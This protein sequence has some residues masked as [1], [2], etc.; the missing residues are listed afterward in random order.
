MRASILPLLL[1][2]ACG[3][4]PTTTVRSR[5]EDVAKAAFEALK[6]GE[7]GPLEPYLMTSDEAKAMTGVAADDTTGRERWNRLVMQHHDR[8]N[9]DWDTAAQGPTKVKYGPM[10]ENA[11]V[12][13]AIQSDRGAVSVEI[14]VTK[15]GRRFVFEGVKPAAGS[16]PKEAAPEEDGG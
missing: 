14:S 15:A 10:N 11:I 5:P 1:L 16:E 7:I 2:A 6:A 13:M 8:L 3:S 9:V 4:K 12:T